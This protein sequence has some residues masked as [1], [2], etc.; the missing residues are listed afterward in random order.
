[1]KKMVCLLL[2]AVL[3]CGMGSFAVAEQAQSITLMASQNWIKDVDREL[4]KVFE[5]E[6]G[7]EVKILVTPDNGYDTLLGTSLAGGSNAIDLFMYAAGSMMVSAG[8]PEIALDLSGEEWV[9]RL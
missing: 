9:A 5:K 7:I 1:M 6:T 2:V 4:F 3:L 8:I